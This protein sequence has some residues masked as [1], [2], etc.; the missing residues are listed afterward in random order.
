VLY[1]QRDVCYAT[2][3]REAANAKYERLH[4]DRP[5]HDG[6]FSSTWSSEPSSRYPYK[7]DMGVTIGVSETDLRPDDA[8][9]TDE[10]APWPLPPPE[11]GPDSE[12]HG[13]DH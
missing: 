8:F 3:E 13:G 10:K 12:D 4:K 6:T 1:P 7:Y 11:H 9:L 5:W 2:M